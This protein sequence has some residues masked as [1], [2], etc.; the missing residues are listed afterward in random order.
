MFL[1]FCQ[2]YLN[3]KVVSTVCKTLLLDGMTSPIKRFVVATPSR[4]IIIVTPPQERKAFRLQYLPLKTRLVIS[5]IKITTCAVEQLWL[6]ALVANYSAKKRY[7]PFKKLFEDVL[8]L[9]AHED[10]REP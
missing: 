6:S 10:A 2:V 8:N 7:L 9:D 5:S 4:K 1:P 3:K